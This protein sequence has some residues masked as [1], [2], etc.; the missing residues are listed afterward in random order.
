MNIVA[1]VIY[2]NLQ[3]CQL[4]PA[5]SLVLTPTAASC[6]QPSPSSYKFFL[7]V[8][9]ANFSLTAFYVFSVGRTEL[10]H[11]QCLGELFTCSRRQQRLVRLRDTEVFF[12]SE[13]C[14]CRAGRQRFA[15][16]DG[17]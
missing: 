16:G 10:L 9:I 2:G 13:K 7:T 1:A 17:C 5:S 3:T 12:S 8:A 11:R 14:L 4:L 6:L 15:P